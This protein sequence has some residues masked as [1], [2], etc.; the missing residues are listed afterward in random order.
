[1]TLVTGSPLIARWRD[2]LAPTSASLFI[3]GS[4]ATIPYASPPATWYMVL[5][6][7]V[8]A[9]V[10]VCGRFDRM[11]RWESVVIWPIL[12]LLGA[13]GIS[14]ATSGAPEISMLRSASMLLFSI[15][16]IAAQIAGWNERALRTVIIGIVGTMLVCVLDLVWQKWTGR[17]LIQGLDA[18]PSGN[19]GS[20]GNRN[21][22]AVVSLLLPF[23]SVL[24][25]GGKGLFLFLI[26][27]AASSPSWILSASRQTGL[28][29]IIAVIGPFVARSSRRIAITFSGILLAIFLIVVA[30]SASLQ[31]RAI[32]TWRSGLADRQE[33]IAF[34]AHLF[35]QHPLTGVGPGMYGA[36]YRDAA[37]KDW[38]WNG[39]TLPKVGMPWVHSIPV[40]VLCETGLVGAAAILAIL[41]GTIR[42]LRSSFCIGGTERELAIAISTALVVVLLIGLIDL[43]F[44]KDWFRCTWWLIL[45]LAFANGHKSSLLRSPK[46]G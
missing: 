23:S 18:A 31:Q 32:E 7:T 25:R 44:V 30:S 27:A 40:E 2:Q 14:I 19:A 42:R 26:L 45:G 1:M 4:L 12:V 28:G 29:W 46:T 9:F 21:D 10:V 17:S 24:I 38:S 3:I 43:S 36:H 6:G 34:G 37:L 13:W 11:K 41:S 15:L 39:T 16:F 5:L 20:Q 35:W 33:I 22:L 8:A